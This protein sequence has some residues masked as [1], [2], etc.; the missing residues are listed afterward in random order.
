MTCETVYGGD[1]PLHIGGEGGYNQSDQFP[2]VSVGE[3]HKSIRKIF[4][5]CYFMQILSRGSILFIF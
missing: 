5:Y 2:I 3:F 1:Y 4:Q